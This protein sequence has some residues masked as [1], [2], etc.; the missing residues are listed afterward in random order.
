M[1]IASISS[2]EE[3]GAVCAH[4]FADIIA[5]R[6]KSFGL[7]CGGLLH[8]NYAGRQWAVEFSLVDEGD[9]EDGS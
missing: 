3:I 2:P 7:I 5:E 4:E 1:T 8:V 6:K 9:E